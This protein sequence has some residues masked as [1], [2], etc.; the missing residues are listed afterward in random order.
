MRTDARGEGAARWP[1]A[2][3]W[4][5]PARGEVGHLSS[6]RGA[7]ARP[8][9]CSLRLGRDG[10]RDALA[11]RIATAAGRVRVLSVKCS[12]EMAAS[13]RIPLLTKISEN[14]AD[15]MRGARALGV[16]QSLRML[17]KVS[18]KV[19][20][21]R[22]RCGCREGSRSFC[23]VLPGDGC[24]G[25]HTT[26]DQNIRECSRSDLAQGPQVAATGPEGRPAAAR[27]A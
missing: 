7:R 26:G 24:I 5:L 25:F 1:P 18:P 19:F 20:T 22:R 13:G 23:R 15:L 6:V 2:V 21:H 14:A 4:R 16:D 3:R 17:A 10:A 11:T 9:I 8:A 27:P 12:Q